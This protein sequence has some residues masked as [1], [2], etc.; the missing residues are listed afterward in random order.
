MCFQPHILVDCNTALLSRLGI[1]RYIQFYIVIVATN[2]VCASVSC[3][4]QFYRIHADYYR[5]GSI[6]Y[7]RIFYEIIVLHIIINI[8][9]IFN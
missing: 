3:I 4:W 2:N 8:I 7:S 1:D 9:I 6:F 5:S